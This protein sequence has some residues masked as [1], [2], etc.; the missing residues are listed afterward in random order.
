[1]RKPPG[2]AQP[3]KWQWYQQ[4]NRHANAGD[5]FRTDT[6]LSSGVS[7]Q[8]DDLVEAGN[9]WTAVERPGAGASGGGLEEIIARGDASSRSIEWTHWRMGSIPSQRATIWCQGLL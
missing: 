3:N 2:Q 9:A 8:N 1:M 5:P 6:D 4:N 7:N